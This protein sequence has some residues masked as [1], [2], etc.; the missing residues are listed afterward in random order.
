MI[1]LSKWNQYTKEHSKEIFSLTF[2][3]SNLGNKNCC[4]NTRTFSEIG[5]L[6]YDT[7]YENRYCLFVG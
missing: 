1:D 4:K 5:D 6:R 2:S 3:F 7:R